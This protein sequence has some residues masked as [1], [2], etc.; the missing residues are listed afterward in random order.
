MWTE[1]M[2]SCWNSQQRHKRLD[3]IILS[4]CHILLF[5]VTISFLIRFHFPLDKIKSFAVLEVTRAR[6]KMKTESNWMNRWEMFTPAN[7]E[8]WSR[9]FLHL[10]GIS[11]HLRF[12]V[13]EKS[14][15]D[16]A[17]SISDF[18]LNNWKQ[19]FLPS[20]NIIRLHLFFLAIHNE[21]F[22]TF[23]TNFAN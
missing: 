16:T 14:I 22:N 19:F 6:I 15:R 17:T 12:K 7:I 21:S 9:M 20:L 1:S 2:Y 4:R 13:L 5:Q 8:S 11:S 23:P 18:F 10:C 3:R